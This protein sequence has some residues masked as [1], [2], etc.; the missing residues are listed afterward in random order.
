AEGFGAVLGR[1]TATGV[2]V[3]SA[4]VSSFAGGACGR[5]RGGNR[6]G[7]SGF[8][9]GGRG[10]A[11]WAADLPSTETDAL[12]FLQAMLTS[13]PAMRRA[14]TSSDSAIWHWHAGHLTRW[15]MLEWLSR[16]RTAEA[17][18]SLARARPAVCR[19]P[20]NAQRRHRDAKR[21]V[22]RVAP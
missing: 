11:G 12:H 14:N 17:P 21:A 10:A 20:P 9:D 6:A 3:A 18:G 8:E 15:D 7:G 16:C 19:A 1:G 5:G 22:N 13:L 4:G 2:V